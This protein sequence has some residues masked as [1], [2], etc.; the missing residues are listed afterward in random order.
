M[1]SDELSIGVTDVLTKLLQFT[2]QVG[3]RDVILDRV[4]QNEAKNCHDSL[5]GSAG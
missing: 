5:W 3:C 4:R 2:R 1:I